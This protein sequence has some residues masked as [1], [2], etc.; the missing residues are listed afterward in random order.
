MCIRDRLRFRRS[1]L[2]SLDRWRQ[3][4]V[5]PNSRYAVFDT[6]LGRYPEGADQDYAAYMDADAFD[7]DIV[8]KLSDYIQTLQADRASLAH[9]ASAARAQLLS[10]RAEREHKG[11]SVVVL[12]EDPCEQ[13]Q[14]IEDL[15]SALLQEGN[16]NQQMCNRMERLRQSLERAVKEKAEAVRSLN[17]VMSSKLERLETCRSSEGTSTSTSS[18]CLLYTSD[19]ADEEDSVDLGGR[20]IIKKKK[21]HHLD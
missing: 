9:Q 13:Q 12:G 20:R 14:Q 10:Q 8:D 18:N 4:R 11:P 15:K 1:Q 17:N 3:E 19:A 21:I 16:N 2:P 7:P 6:L 5:A